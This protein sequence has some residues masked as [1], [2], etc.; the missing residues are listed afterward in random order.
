MLKDIRSA[1]IVATEVRERGV[2][3]KRRRLNGLNASPVLVDLDQS[4][5]GKAAGCDP[6]EPSRDPLPEPLVS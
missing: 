6:Q 2:I 1:R 5:A 4:I 3:G